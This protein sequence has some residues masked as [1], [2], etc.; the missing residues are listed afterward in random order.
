MQEG[1]LGEAADAYLAK[2]D[3]D[4]PLVEAIRSVVS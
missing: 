4:G 3:E 1:E 2:S